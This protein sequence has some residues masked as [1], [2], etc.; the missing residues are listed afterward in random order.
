MLEIGCGDTNIES[1]SQSTILSLDSESFGRNRSG[2]NIQQ[3]TTSEVADTDTVMAYNKNIDPPLP[4]DISNV[5]SSE[6]LS[7]QS[8]SYPEKYKRAWLKAKVICSSILYAGEFPYA[9]IIEL[10]IALNHK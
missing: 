1:L 4:H 6:D 5:F 7:S 10:S 2:M 8:S 9:C 3:P